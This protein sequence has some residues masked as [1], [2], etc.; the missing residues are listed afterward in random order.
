MYDGKC[1]IC[2]APAKYRDGAEE[3]CIS[4]YAD[5]IEECDEEYDD[6]YDDL[7]DY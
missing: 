7:E 5:E 2:G 4:C 1:D 6:A 3:F